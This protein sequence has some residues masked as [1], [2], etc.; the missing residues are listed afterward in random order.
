MLRLLLRSIAINL[1]SI[2]IA[3]RILA[4]IIVF[5]G[6]TRTLLMAAVAIAVVN[7]L[8]RPLVNLL[9]LPIH[10]VSLGVFRWI[11][12]LVSLYIVTLIVPG[13]Q[14]HAFISP[15]LDLKY[16]MIPTLHFSAFGAFLV[17][18]L[19]L[20]LSFHLIYWLLQD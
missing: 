4:N 3:S 16:I 12:N 14:I 19:V 6:G 5:V 20:T 2:Y 8:V 10:L 11:A 7:L 1:A 17:A 9:L 13:L 18:T 15:P